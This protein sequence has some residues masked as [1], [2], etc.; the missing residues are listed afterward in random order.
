MQLPR[1]FKVGLRPVKF[2]ATPQG[3]MDVL[4]LDWKTGEFVRAMQYLSRCCE[5]DPEVDDM[6]ENE[7]LEYVKQLRKEIEVKK[8]ETEPAS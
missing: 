5:G 7:F 1:Y 6:E 3:G 4:A 8:N 2:V